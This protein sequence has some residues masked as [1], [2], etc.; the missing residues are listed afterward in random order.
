MDETKQRDC[1]RSLTIDL[2]SLWDAA[3]RKSKS[4]KV[5]LEDGVHVPEDE[6]KVA[7]KPKK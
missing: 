2:G 1:D 5:V 4:S 6:L 7:T 3:S